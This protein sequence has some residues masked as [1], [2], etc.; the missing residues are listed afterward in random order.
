MSIARGDDQPDLRTLQPWEGHRKRVRRHQSWTGFMI[1]S[2]EIPDATNSSADCRDLGPLPHAASNGSYS[3]EQIMSRPRTYPGLSLALALTSVVLFATA[4]FG[5]GPASSPSD[6]ESEVRA[7]KAENAAVR[8][9]LRKM[10]EQQKALLEQVE[11][12]Q[13]RFDGVANGAVQP[14]APAQVADAGELVNNELK[15]ELTNQ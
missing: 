6:L 13:R 3:Q 12:L 9:L 5:Q 7:V 10:E 8:E 15:N 1:A 4:A 14:S 2:N 11:R